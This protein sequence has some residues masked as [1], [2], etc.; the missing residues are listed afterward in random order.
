M[1]NYELQGLHLHFGVI[2]A[3]ILV[4]D[5]SALVLQVTLTDPGQTVHNISLSKSLFPPVILLSGLN[6]VLFSVAACY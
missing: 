3:F 1:R 5:T 6:K 2:T 4:L